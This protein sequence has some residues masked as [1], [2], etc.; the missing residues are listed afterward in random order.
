MSIKVGQI[1]CGKFGN[2]I[3]SKLKQ[4]KYVEVVKVIRSQDKWWELEDVNWVIV[5]TP[6]EFHYEQSKYY[7]EKSINVF[8]EKPAAFSSKAVK[9]L[10]SIAE[11]NRCQF[12]VDDV[13]SYENIEATNHFIYKKWGRAFSNIIDRI[14]YHHFYLIYDKIKT[15]KYTLRISLNETLNKIF[16]LTFGSDEFTFEYD[17]DWYKK[18]THNINSTSN[19]DALQDMLTA[20]LYNTADFKLNKKQTLFATKLS[21][22]IKPKLYGNVAVVGAGIY[23]ITS[24]I[25]LSN[26]GYEVDLFESKGDILAATS[27]I[28]QYRIHRGYHYPRSKDTILSCRDNE[29]SFV[30]NFKK[31]VVD[32]AEHFYSIASED[33]FTAPRDYL[34]VLDEC[35]LE[36]EIVD[37][38]PNCDLT[39]KVNENLYCPETL[40]SICLDRIKGCGI[41]LFLHRKIK[42]KKELLSY[43]YKIIST[44]SSLND[45]DDTKKDYQF[46]LCE[47]P[48]FKLPQQYS[49]KSIVVMDG[50]FMCFDPYSNTEYHVG[51]NVV[52]AIHTSNI[53]TEP[54]IPPAYKDYINKGI[55]TNPKY[56]NV[57]SFIESAKKFFPD[58]EKA[59]HIGSMYTIRTVLPNKDK[60]DERPTIV[61]FEKDT[62]ILFSGKVV[63][64]IEAADKIALSI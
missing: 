14:A 34:H 33:S 41:N 18:K 57:S 39:V 17:F 4:I 49:N 35:N 45:F 44:Y 6:N 10:Y 61:R 12:Y 27:G 19:S 37:P 55:I 26:K 7:L 53:G 40:K 22:E 2:K 13:L 62:A 64:C 9:E 25:K 21:E 38:L 52:H 29:S 42:D 48:L 11:K 23:G 8:C 56:T 54:I 16:T 3:L 60:T 32:K 30:S 59:E 24:A 58:I 47:K 43:N 15:E 28:N 1:G 5:A 36:W 20:V 51:G 63:N 50:P 31:A 46:E